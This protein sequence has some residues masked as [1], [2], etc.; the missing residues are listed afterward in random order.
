MPF[1][2]INLKYLS[3]I[4]F[5]TRKGEFLDYDLWLQF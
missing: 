5:R 4:P 2:F 3:E 1:L